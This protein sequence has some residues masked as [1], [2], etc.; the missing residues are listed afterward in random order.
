MTNEHLINEHRVG[1]PIGKG[2][3]TLT[4]RL[5]VLQETDST[6]DSAR[7]MAKRG[8]PEGTAVMAIRQ[9][10]GRGRLGHAW[11][12]PE[13]KNL[14]LSLILR[15]AMPPE[16]AMFLSL[17]ASIAVAETVETV[18]V[19]RADLKWPNDVLVDGRKIAGILSEGAMSGSVLELVIIGVGLNVNSVLDDFPPELRS[20]VTSVLLRTGRQTELENLARIFLGRMEHL[21]RRIRNE[22]GEFVV[23][24]WLSRWA[25]KGC[26]LVH[27]GIRGIAEGLDHRGA[28]LLRSDD[29]ST[30]RVLS[31]EV[32]PM[33][34]VSEQDRQ[35]AGTAERGT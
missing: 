20:S 9:S 2:P 7:E 15:P 24:L 3:K 6:Q 23:P 10:K 34:N 35:N 33:D 18:G 27:E 17:L 4:E 11:V 14:A 31:G 32:L 12:S 29:G 25:H 28:L 22:G 19:V 21:Y 30:K 1:D 16:D 8:E 13:G 26:V 5:V